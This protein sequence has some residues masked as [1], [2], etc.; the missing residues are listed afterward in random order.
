[1]S[2]IHR[3]WPIDATRFSVRLAPIWC[4]LPGFTGA[5]CHH[6]VSLE[7]SYHGGRD[8]TARCPSALMRRKRMPVS[9]RCMPTALA[10]FQRRRI[11]RKLSKRVQ[12]TA[13]SSNSVRRLFANIEAIGPACL[14]EVLWQP[15]SWHWCSSSSRWVL[16][17]TSSW[18]TSE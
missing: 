16:P 5:D 6:R 9:L 18:S 12:T 4:D 11:R 2:A 3:S 7:A 1:M 13:M 8:A 15:N 14:R 10:T 17:P